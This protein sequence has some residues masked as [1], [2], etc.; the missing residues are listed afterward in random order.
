MKNK[1]VGFMV[2]LF[3][4]WLFAK[5]DKTQTSNVTSLSQSNPPST[6][7][8]HNSTS[9]I[10]TDEKSET[11][12]INAD[13]LKVRNA[14]NGNTIQ[15]LKRG[16][17]VRVYE[18]ISSWSRISKDQE[19]ERWVS[20]IYLCETAECYIKRAPFQPTPIPKKQRIEQPKNPQ[21]QELQPRNYSSSCSC[22]SGNVC[23]GPRGGRYCITSGGNK[24]Y[25]V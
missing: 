3:L 14:P 8:T 16:V 13:T 23:I 4:F 2:I 22:S 9:N 10:L 17:Q 11:Y 20:T 6:L 18:Q 21:S 19:E 1:T 5:N 15:S 7:T 25:G 12:Y 24:R